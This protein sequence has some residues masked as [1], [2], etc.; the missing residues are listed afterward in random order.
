M[1]KNVRMKIDT[2]KNIFH[3]NPSNSTNLK[4]HPRN[5]EYCIVGGAF[6]TKDDVIFAIFIAHTSSHSK[7]ASRVH[8]RKI[9]KTK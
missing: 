3:R 9:D 1:H 2:H 5:E 7:T 6:D 8:C 4:N